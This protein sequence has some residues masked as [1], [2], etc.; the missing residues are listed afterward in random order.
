ML[1]SSKLSKVPTVDRLV[2]IWTSRYFP[3][4]STLS[5]NHNSLVRSK[6]REDSSIEGR[7]RAAKKLPKQLIQR[8]CELAAVR[9]K[10]LY[11]HNE[12][13]VLKEVAHLAQSASRIYL[14]LLEVY[15]ESAPIVISSKGNLWETVG[16]TSLEVWG[17]PRVNKLAD[18]LETLLLELQKQHMVSGNWRSLGFITKIDLCRNKT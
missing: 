14:K 16:D 2:N 13:A 17:I 10:A 1:V 3:D 11:A 5:I 9:T 15:Q 7:R 18:T 6:L 12:P 4:L 8:K